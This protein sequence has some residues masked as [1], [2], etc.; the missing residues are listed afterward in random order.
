VE[1]KN[2]R[3]ESKHVRK[4]NKTN[5]KRAQRKEREARGW[6]GRR[7]HLARARGSN[8]EQRVKHRLATGTVGD[9]CATSCRFVV[10]V[11]LGGDNKCSFQTGVVKRLSTRNTHEKL[12]RKIGT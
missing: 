6:G 12:A 5:N 8:E 7:T 4:Q 1:A 9:G 2:K 3:V 10:I 11:G